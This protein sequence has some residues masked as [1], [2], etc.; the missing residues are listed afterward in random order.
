[1]SL[2]LFASVNICLYDPMS[3][4][5]KRVN[6]VSD[7]QL[8]ENP[9]M[10]EQ[11]LE[12]VGHTQTHTHRHMPHTHTQTHATHTYMHACTYTCTVTL[13]ILVPVALFLAVT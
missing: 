3:P 13:S 1:M 8:G 7:M 9:L 11:I 12:I 4:A 10:P 6:D 5:G 2:I